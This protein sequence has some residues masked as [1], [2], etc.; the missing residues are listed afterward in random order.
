MII[1]IK[2][3][4]VFCCYRAVKN[5]CLHKHNISRIICNNKYIYAYYNYL[6]I[7]SYYFSS[8]Y[9]VPILTI[10][11]VLITYTLSIPILMYKEKL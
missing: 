6:C 7:L 3:Y 1:L 2:K 10:K 9:Y 5:I 8:F 4:T 11:N